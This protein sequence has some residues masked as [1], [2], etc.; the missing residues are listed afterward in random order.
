MKQW[1]RTAGSYLWRIFCGIAL[2]L[3]FAASNAEAAQISQVVLSHTSIP[4]YEKLE[5]TVSTPNSYSNPFDPAEVDLWGE[6]NGPGQFVK[7][8]GFWTGSQWKIR[9]AARQSGAWNVTVKLRD[10]ASESAISKSFTVTPGSKP[11]YIQ[12]STQDPRYFEYSNGTPYYGVGFCR[13]WSVGSVPNFFADMAA[14]GCNLLV[15]WLPH[16][17]NML[18]TNGTGYARYDMTRAQRIDDVVAQCEARDIAL[19]LTIWNHDELRDSTHS[20]GNASFA[21]QNPFVQISNA[22]GFFSNQTSWKYQQNL[23][24]YI[25]A[26]WGYSRA[27][28]MWQTVSEITGTNAIYDP[29]A[30]STNP[31]GWHAKITRYFSENDPF[32]HP[33]TGSKHG[34]LDWP[35]GFSLMDVPQIHSYDTAN[36][37]VGIAA[38]I[39]HWTDLMSSRY[40][41]PNF[42]GEFGTSNL[43]LEPDFLHNGIWAGIM[44]GAAATPMLWNDGNAWGDMTPQMFTHM[45]HLRSFADAIDWSDA[46]FHITNVFGTSYFY[47]NLSGG[48]I[49]G[50][51]SSTKA[52]AWLQD[53]TP[54]ETIAGAQITFTGMPPGNYVPRFYNTWTG[55]WSAG[56][57][58]VADK[59]RVTVMCPSFSRDIA[60]LLEQDD[61]LVWRQEPV[62]DFDAGSEAWTFWG[63]YGNASCTIGYNASL[64]APGSSGGSCALNVSFPGGTWTDVKVMRTYPQPVDFSRSEAVEMVL[65]APPGIPSELSARP[66]VTYGSGTFVESNYFQPLMAGKWNTLRIYKGDVPDFSKVTALGL[67]VGGSVAFSG[68]MAVDRV[69]RIDNVASTV[70]DWGLY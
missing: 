65:W 12:Q 45:R 9:F 39:A 31:A 63:R 32:D 28:G 16:W 21:T 23:Y 56:S 20:W 17:D 4:T 70:N 25:I 69:R 43:A 24:R 30:L 33:I 41:K 52:I 29:I 36:N 7:V 18:V 19:I 5:L 66:A 27:I 6:F 58:T 61:T 15:Y 57:L 37:K 35:E 53:T 50:L 68:Q 1:Q 42:I 54:G 47:T 26:R 44:S 40:A 60:V 3:S 2:T 64:N 10:A 14:N 51:R 62:F 11:G 49:W 38:R 34:D 8:N 48:K 13:A 22:T 59:G 46:N 55:V 67:K